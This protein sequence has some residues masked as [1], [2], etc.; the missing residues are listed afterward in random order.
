MTMNNDKINNS[1]K[2]NLVCNFWNLELH[3]KNSLL[4]QNV[5]AIIN[6]L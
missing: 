5:E 1:W 2:G 3:I 6:W 4:C